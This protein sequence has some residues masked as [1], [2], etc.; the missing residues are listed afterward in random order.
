VEFLAEEPGVTYMVANND[1]EPEGFV[2]D[3][4]QDLFCAATK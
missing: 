4:E 2:I 3:A 1:V